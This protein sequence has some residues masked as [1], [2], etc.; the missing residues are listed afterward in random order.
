M[1]RMGPDEGFLL[2]ATPQAE[3][4]H[5]ETVVLVAVHGDEGSLGFVLNRPSACTLAEAMV[6]LGIEGRVAP[7]RLAFFGGR[8]RPDIGWMLFDARACVEP[9][10][11]C[12][13]SPEVG[14][15]AAADAMGAILSVNAPALL[16]LGHVTWEP[17][18]LDDE[19]ASGAWIR[20]P[21]VDPRLVFETPIARRWSDA[22]CDV[23]G[24]PR[25]WLGVAR[26]ATA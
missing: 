25:P 18:D 13:L 1:F 6:N 17:G 22:T 8:T 11:S 21:F 15:T 20:A 12:L 10:D 26:F 23:L 4:E 7:D 14:V 19:I 24:M 9:E 16:L 3:T 5:R 2:V